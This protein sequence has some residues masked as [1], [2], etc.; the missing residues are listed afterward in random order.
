MNIVFDFGA[1]LFRWQP[2]ELVTQTFPDQ[3]ATPQAAQSLASA[4]FSHSDWHAFDQGLV[5]PE[6]V[7]RKSAERLLLPL[8]PLRDLVNHIGHL[9]TPIEASVQVL[10]GLHGLKRIQPE[11]RLYFL[12]NMP[13]LYAR[14]LE[15]LHG[16]LR[17][18]D[19][20]LFSGDVHLVKPD[21]ALY[22]LLE[23]RYS[24]EP[25]CTL[26]VDDL[27]VNVDAARSRGWQG[28]HFESAAQLKDQLSSL[29]GPF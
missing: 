27:S 2:V 19:G 22:A 5:S 11:L 28:I 20:G 21:P 10:A 8:A 23:R 29:V 26:F 18:F 15:Q 24:L 7:V 6:Q 4:L 12:S 25:A 13:A 9:L 3:A 14:E 1:V 17:W 16:F